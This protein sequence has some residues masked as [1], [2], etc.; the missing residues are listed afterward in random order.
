MFPPSSD[1]RKPTHDTLG[2]AVFPRDWENP[3]PAGRYNL[4]VLGGGA[5]GLVTAVGAARLGARVA[6]V[7]RRHTGGDCLNHGCVPSKA[8]IASARRLAH[9]RSAGEF[10]VRTGDV[11][12]D[13]AA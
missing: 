13:F 1:R 9:V 6:L 12:L 4:V 10:G 2:D 11:R 7:E 5:A 8:L 3:A